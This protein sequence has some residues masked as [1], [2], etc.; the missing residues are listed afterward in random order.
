ML[1]FIIIH[2]L[3]LRSLHRPYTAPIYP[4]RFTDFDQS[5]VR[6]PFVLNKERPVSN[7]PKKTERQGRN[8]HNHPLFKT[9]GKD[10]D[11]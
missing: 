1:A 3:R 2:L 9:R 6:I 11:E 4:F 5:Q 10:I 8:S 7:L